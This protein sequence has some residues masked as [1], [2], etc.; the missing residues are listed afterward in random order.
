MLFSTT[1]TSKYFI[2]GASGKKS[3]VDIHHIFPKNYLTLIGYS[4]DRDRNQIANF[5]YLDYSTNIDISDNPPDTYVDK[6]RK[7]FGEE[8]YKKACEQNALPED[9]EKLEYPVFLN[10][11]RVLMAGLI[12]KA[13]EELSK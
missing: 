4:D 5:T 9:F 7:R 2:V 13:Y 6:Y 8:G 3:A 11:R 10:K 12:K 1:P